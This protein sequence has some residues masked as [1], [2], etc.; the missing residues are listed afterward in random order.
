M[1]KERPPLA[2]PYRQSGE[3]KGTGVS[4]FALF[5]F[6][7]SQDRESIQNYLRVQN[8]FISLSF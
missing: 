6:V 3:Y 8:I 7:Q 2:P 4:R 1:P 5:R